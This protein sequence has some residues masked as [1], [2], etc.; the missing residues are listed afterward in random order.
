MDNRTKKLIQS[1]IL[2]YLELNIDGFKIAGKNGKNLFKC[3]LC[4]EHPNEELTANIFPLN[5]NKVYCFDPKHKALGDIFDM[6]KIFE[7]GMKEL[8]EDEIGEYLVE[9]L[10][11]KTNDEVQKLLT[12]YES[13]NWSLVPLRKGGKEADVEFEWQL[14]SIVKNR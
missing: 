10:K 13:L 4:H 7:P 1:Y 2:K 12:L 11:I 3:P 14:K 5:S 6:V 8:N 9:L